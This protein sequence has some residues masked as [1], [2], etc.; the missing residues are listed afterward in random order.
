M[1]A[2]LIKPSK[3]KPRII[4]QEY[5]LPKARADSPERFRNLNSFRFYGRYGGPNYSAG[6]YDATARELIEGVP[7]DKLDELTK[8]HDMYYTLGKSKEGD[9]QLIDDAVKLI[10][11]NDLIMLKLNPYGFAK[12]L[13]NE[14]SMSKSALALVLGF[15]LKKKLSDLGISINDPTKNKDKTTKMERKEMKEILR[16]YRL[17]SAYS[18]IGADKY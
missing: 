3:N 14:T 1:Y 12:D 13:L 2:S 10:K 18:N 4:K 9:A 15:K 11:P 5:T 8:Y 17:K 6:K 7:K 16:K